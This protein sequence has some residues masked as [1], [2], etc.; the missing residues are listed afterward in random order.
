MEW[1]CRVP[2]FRH[3]VILKQLGIAVGIPF[4]IVA[5][6]IWLTSGKSIYLLYAL[7]LIAALF[8]LTWLFILALYGGKYDVEFTLN[9]DGVRCRTGSKQARKNRIVNALTVGLGLFSGRLTTAGAGVLAQSRQDVFLKWARITKV[10]YRPGSQTIL[11]RGGWTE[12]VA[13]FCTEENYAAVEQMVRQ[14]VMC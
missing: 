11:L 12:N 14:Q 7:G 5:I 3:P 9:S 10:K 13:I 8:L 6:I 4:G 2:I 1:A